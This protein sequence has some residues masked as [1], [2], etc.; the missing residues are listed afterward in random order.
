[1]STP[2]SSP[3]VPPEFTSTEAT[4]VSELD[5]VSM[6]IPADVAFVS[7][8]RL[9]AASLAARCDLT[10]DDIEDLRLAVDE[11][12]A[13]LLPH[14][15]AGSSVNAHFELTRGRLLVET[16]VQT[17]QAAAPD[18]DSFGW[19]VLGALTNSVAVHEKDSLLTIVLSKSREAAQR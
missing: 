14:A 4:R 18:R 16:S 2:E 15:A 3:E 9:T 19:T 13:L 11:A 10:V 6:Q 17:D 1:M 5:V 12:C 7:T 8:L